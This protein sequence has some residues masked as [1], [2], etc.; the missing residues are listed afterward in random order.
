MD[1]IG[2]I[3]RLPEGNSHMQGVVSLPVFPGN[4]GT[5]QIIFN[6]LVPVFRIWWNSHGISRIASPARIADS[7]SVLRIPSP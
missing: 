3:N 7:L 2:N 1:L 5:V 6:M 4:S